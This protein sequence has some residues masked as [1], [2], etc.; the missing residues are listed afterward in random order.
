MALL[1]YCVQLSADRVV[2]WCY[3]IWYAVVVALYFDPTPSIWL[4][5][6]GISAV[7]G[8]ALFLSVN[9]ARVSGV[10]LWPTVRLF[11]MPFCVSS[12]AA[13]IKGQGFWVIVPPSSAARWACVGACVGFVL[14]VWLLKHF[15]A[16]LPT[17]GARM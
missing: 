8:F 7:I 15:A 11:L 12:F 6:L 2:L 10:Q 5:A 17:T 1:R 13:L 14:G 4:N 3:L 16:P 9:G